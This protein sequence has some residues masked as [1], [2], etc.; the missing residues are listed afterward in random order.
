MVY[1]NSCNISMIMT[2]VNVHSG[3]SD[4]KGPTSLSQKGEANRLV[5]FPVSK[6]PFLTQVL[7]LSKLTCC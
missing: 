4:K 1:F 5:A 3:Y 7:Q 2:H 6:L